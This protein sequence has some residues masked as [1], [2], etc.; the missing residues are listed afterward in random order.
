[1]AP[2]LLNEGAGSGG[3]VSAGHGAQHFGVYVVQ[4]VD[5]SSKYGLGIEVVRSAPKKLKFSLLKRNSYYL[6]DILT[7]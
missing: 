7:T 2:N 6:S 3:G 4:W 1:M 5:Y